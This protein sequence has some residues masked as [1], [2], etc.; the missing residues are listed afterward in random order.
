MKA[1]GFDDFLQRMKVE[2]KGNEKGQSLSAYHPEIGTYQHRMISNSRFRI[3]SIEASLKKETILQF[4]DP[5]LSSSVNLCLNL[6]GNLDTR[7]DEKNITASLAKNTQHYNYVP[8]DHYQLK[9]NSPVHCIH[10]AVNKEYYFNLLGES[11]E[12][13]DKFKQ[14]LSRNETLCSESFEMNS[15][16]IAIL[17][18]L[19]R[20]EY[21]GSLRDLFIEGK[22]LELIARQLHQSHLAINKKANGS[23]IDK[24]LFHEIKSFIDDTFTHEHSLRSLAR[25]F[26]T[27]EFKLK[28]GFRQ[29]FGVSVFAYIHSKRMTHALNLIKDQKTIMEVAS[30]I[31]YKNSNHFS[32]AFKR[33]FGMIPSAVRCGC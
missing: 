29:T 3:T 16:T 1:I 8:A 25:Q 18:N 23:K 12:W 5:G 14:K 21:A 2:E 22:I 28:Q 13:S 24:D 33:K 19:L 26:G 7:F 27:N 11:E 9:L 10:I 30:E 32:T 15:D 20:I 4:K 31:G 6:S 17:L